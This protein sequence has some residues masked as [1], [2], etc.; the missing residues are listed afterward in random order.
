MSLAYLNHTGNRC[1]DCTLDV[2]YSG[3][4][5]NPE[6]HHSVRRGPHNPSMPRNTPL[7]APSLIPQLQSLPIGSD[8]FV[9]APFYPTC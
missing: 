5:V 7:T 8:S 2:T 1:Q 4:L 3:A 9:L 6:P